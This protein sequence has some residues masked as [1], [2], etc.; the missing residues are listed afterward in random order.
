V[1]SDS[2]E[3]DLEL[4]ISFLAPRL[5]WQGNTATR[6]QVIAGQTHLKGLLLG[7]GGKAACEAWERW[8]G[9]KPDLFL[10]AFFGT[11]EV[12]PCYK[13]RFDGVFAVA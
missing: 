12:M 11:T 1:D 10:G 5:I 9:L 8:Q 4:A 3:G 13:A 6:S 7:F 2:F